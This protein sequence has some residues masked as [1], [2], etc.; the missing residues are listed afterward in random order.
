MEKRKSPMKK[1]IK[2]L[3]IFCAFISVIVTVEF[4]VSV[5]HIKPVSLKQ[6]FYLTCQCR[7]LD[8]EIIMISPHLLNDDY[9]K[10]QE[11]T[12]Q[13]LALGDSFT[14]GYPV[15]QEESYP[16]MLANF[17]N[18]N[19]L[20]MSMI[21]CGIG[22]TGPDQ[23]IKLLE[24]RILAKTTPDIVVWQ[25]YVNDIWDNVLLPAYSLS[26]GA[27]LPLSGS[28]SWI[29]KRQKFFN[30]IPLPLSVKRGSF[31]ISL[32]LKAFEV[33]EWLQVPSEYW[34]NPR[35]WGWK[36]FELEVEKMKALSKK[37]GFKLFF[38]LIP[39]QAVYLSESKENTADWDAS[40]PV[41]DYKSMVDL[42]SKQD[43]FIDARFLKSDFTLINEAFP[44]QTLTS[45]IEKDLF[46]GADIDHN[47]PGDRHLNRFGYWLLARKVGAYIAAHLE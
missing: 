26:S 16:A 34:G 11:Q 12:R 44:G 32:I 17:F 45:A 8:D 39:P 42:L 4:I 29:Y 15:K 43:H 13:L 22:N 41:K 2:Y 18:K 30:A 7:N 14:E 23:Q 10:R 20:K 40:W 25:L 9:Y 36:K 47:P 28:S 21:N 33:G 27:L 1:I 5:F 38:L 3:I 46:S 31:F 24:N 19:N 37:Y 35:M 6:D